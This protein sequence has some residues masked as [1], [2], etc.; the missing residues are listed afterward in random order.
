LALDDYVANRTGLLLI[1]PCKDLLSDGGKL[2]PKGFDNQ[3][4]THRRSS[5]LND[6]PPFRARLIGNDIPISS[7][8]VN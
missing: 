5:S 1:D 2:W 4:Q 3:R 6:D 8:A 7:H